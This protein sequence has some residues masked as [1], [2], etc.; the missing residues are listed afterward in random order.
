M[1]TYACAADSME[2]ANS[3]Q[4]VSVDDVALM[5]GDSNAGAYAAVEHTLE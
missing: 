2:S 3:K 1:C 4:L 5:N